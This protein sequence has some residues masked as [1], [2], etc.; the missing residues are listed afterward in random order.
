MV[1]QK[2]LCWLYP[3]GT[4]FLVKVSI[5]H[6][7]FTFA[8]FCAIF[9]RLSW[10]D[11]RHMGS[12]FLMATRLC[13]FQSPQ[14]AGIGALRV[15]QLGGG[16][17]CWAPSH[18]WSWV[19]LFSPFSTPAVDLIVT[20]ELYSFCGWSCCKTL[21]LTALRSKVHPFSLKVGVALQ[22]LGRETSQPLF[23]QGC[24][25]HKCAFVKLLVAT[26]A[27][28]SVRNYLSSFPRTIATRSRHIQLMPQT[29]RK[30]QI[31]GT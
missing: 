16:Q 26:K 3:S 21:T 9:P 18:I 22:N 13:C 6:L 31:L 4:I 28:D 19:W 5:F 12:T 11:R 8:R 15:G 10:L 17:R 30:W 1:R 29:Q 23:S 25:A 24:R 2:I 14:A 7:W 27:G 20:C